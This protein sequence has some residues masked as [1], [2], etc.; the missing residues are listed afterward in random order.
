VTPANRAWLETIAHVLDHGHDLRQGDHVTMREV[1]CHTVRVPM[2]QPLVTLASRNLTYRYTRP[3]AGHCGAAYTEQYSWI[4]RTLKE[5]NTSRHAVMKIWSEGS[6][7]RI[8]CPYALSLQWLIRDAQLHCISTT[9]SSDVWQDLPYDFHTLS[10]LSAHL[11][12]KLKR[13][14]RLEVELGWLHNTAGSRYL[15]KLDWK[16]AL[17]CLDPLQ[18]TVDFEYAPLDLRE[19]EKPGDLIDLYWQLAHRASGYSWKWLAE[20]FTS[21]PKVG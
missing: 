1:L 12:L 19:F 13:D 10:V 4:A 16:A 5:D 11:A 15:H 14:H 8:D 20:S 2:D 3:F 7:S 6:K 18:S 21:T 17:D 9:R